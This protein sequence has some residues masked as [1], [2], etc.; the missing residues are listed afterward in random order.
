VPIDEH[1]VV[2]ALLEGQLHGRVALDLERLLLRLAAEE[3]GA[4][5]WT[6]VWVP[7]LEVPGQDILAPR[8][9]APWPLPP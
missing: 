1:P 6:E 9:K 8:P 5:D 3:V 4:I 2:V 7:G